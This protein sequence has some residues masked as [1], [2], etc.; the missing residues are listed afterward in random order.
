MCVCVYRNKYILALHVQNHFFC[1]SSFRRSINTFVRRCI[2]PYYKMLRFS[3]LHDF[4]VPPCALPSYSSFFVVFI[5]F[6]LLL[7]SSSSSYS[8]FCWCRALFSLVQ[9]CIAYHTQS[10]SLAFFL[11][12]S[13]LLSKARARARSHS[14]KNS[15]SVIVG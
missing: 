3:F 7:S 6:L 11:C 12:T 1:C 5:R 9:N 2:S 4:S 14:T 15:R 10:I 13:R 8:H